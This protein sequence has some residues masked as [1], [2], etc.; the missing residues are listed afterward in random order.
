MNFRKSRILMW[1]GF[2]VGFFIMVLGIGIGNE[3]VI[4]YFMAIGS[5]VFF[6]ALIQAF[7]FYTCPHCGY[8]LMNVRG[9]IPEHCPKCGKEL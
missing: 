9:E 4:S 8:S 7:V 5:V 2:A 3:K 1:V 6:V